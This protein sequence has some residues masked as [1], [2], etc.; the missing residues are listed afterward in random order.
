MEH[1]HFGIK[2]IEMAKLGAMVIMIR[3]LE[4][5]AAF[6]TSHSHLC[7]FCSDA[8]A[9]HHPIMIYLDTFMQFP[10]PLS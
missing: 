6:I 7:S 5:K 8:I 1:D 4:P 3:F 10:F 2:R 9:R